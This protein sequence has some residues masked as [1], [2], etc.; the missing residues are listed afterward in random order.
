VGSLVALYCVVVN[1]F[2]WPADLSENFLVEV[3]LRFVLPIAVV[4]ACV[5]RAEWPVL[6]AAVKRASEGRGDQAEN[7]SK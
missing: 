1:T 5:P 6:L 7:S 2:F 4:V 3:L